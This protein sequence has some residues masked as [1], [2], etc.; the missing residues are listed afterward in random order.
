MEA[1]YDEAGYYVEYGNTEFLKYLVLMIHT[2]ELNW[3]LPEIQLLHA[4]S[5]PYIPALRG[6]NYVAA[7][8]LWISSSM[9]LMWLSGF[10]SINAHRCGPPPSL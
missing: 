2:K 6:C 3:I 4:V 9:R 10:P 7:T 8:T 1:Y 5:S